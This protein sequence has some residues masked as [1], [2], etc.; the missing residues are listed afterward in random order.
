MVSNNF[1]FCDEK[2]YDTKQFAI[3]SQI[4]RTKVNA[5][6]MR[7]FLYKPLYAE[8]EIYVMSV[9]VGTYTYVY[10]GEMF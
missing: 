3:Y 8:R 10:N 2:S 6:L 1:F 4:Y 5:F 9:V 7:L